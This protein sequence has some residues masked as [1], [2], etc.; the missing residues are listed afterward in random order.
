MHDQFDVS[1]EDADLLGEVE[2]TT[3]LIIA[4]SESDE[5]LI[6][7]RDRP[8]PRRRRPAPARLTVLRVR[9]AGREQHRPACSGPTA[10]TALARG[11]SAMVTSSPS[12]VTES[13]RNRS[14]KSPPCP[15]RRSRGQR[16]PRVGVGPRLVVVL[17]RHHHPHAAARLG[18]HREPGRPG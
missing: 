4:A 10:R 8:D 16:G 11:V 14:A 5:P 7:R 2:L 18:R 1:L 6:R 17:E 13:T 9:S 15:G 3:N 12:A